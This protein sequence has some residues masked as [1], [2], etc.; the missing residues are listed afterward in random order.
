MHPG[1]I[2]QSGGK[3]PHAIPRPQVNSG[4]GRARMGPEL[5]L[6]W[7]G[8]VFWAALMV[9][10]ERPRLRLRLSASFSDD[11][12]IQASRQAGI[13]QRGGKPPHSISRDNAQARKKGAL[14]SERPVVVARGTR[15][16]GSG[17]GFFALASFRR[18]RRCP[19]AG[20]REPRL[21]RV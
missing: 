8:G 1:A 9:A 16:I 10:I 6:R 18:R 12:H 15:P 7:S 5:R 2:Q 17:R 19:C 11:A 14:W 3:V 20:N 4:Q 13:K 21:L